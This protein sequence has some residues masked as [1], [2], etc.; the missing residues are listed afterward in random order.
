MSASGLGIEFRKTL[1]KRQTTL[2]G[3]PSGY[4]STQGHTVISTRYQDSLSDNDKRC[5]C[6]LSL[7]RQTM[8]RDASAPYH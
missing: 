1:I 4:H 5:Q 7:T 6:S 2:Y 3:L 8:T